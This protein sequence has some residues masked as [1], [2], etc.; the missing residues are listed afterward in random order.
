[1]R[2][3]RPFP[4]DRSN[5]PDEPI[6][7]VGLSCR[8]PG[9]PSPEAFWTLLREG[10]DAISPPPPERHLDART[11]GFLEHVDRFDP[12]FFDI[13]PREAA[14]MDPQQ[15]LI[16]ELSWEA[17]EDAGIVAADV[18]GRKVGVFVGSMWD[19][20][21]TALHRRGE[22]ATTRHS[23][24][25]LHRSIIANRVSYTWDLRGPSMAIDTG[26]SSS[27]VAVHTACE[28]LWRG[29]S[30]LALAAGV[31]LN[32]A[33]EST[34]RSEKFGG[35]SPDGR[36]FTFD[37]RANGYVRGEGAGLVVLKPLSRALADNDRVHCVIRGTAMNNDGASEGLTVPSARA[38]EDVLRE[39]Y[40][41]AGVDLTDVQYV[42]LHGTGT[43]KGDPLESSALGVV[44]GARRTP[45]TSLLVGSVKT[46]IGHLEAAAG[47]AGLIKTV[48][49]IKHRE[50]PPTL[51][52]RTPNPQISFDEWNL[53][54]QTALG[55]WP[56]GDAPLLAGVSSFGMGGTNCH[57]VLSDVPTVTG[58][59]RPG[60]DEAPDGP[61]G[62]ARAVRE[63]RPTGTSPLLPWV[64]TG[65]S[66]AAVRAQAELLR[67]HVADNPGPDPAGIGFSL[68]AHRTAFEERAVVLGHDTGDHLNGLEALVHGTPAPNL[69][70]GSARGAGRTAFLFTG[71]GG[72]RAG[73]GRRL[74]ATVPAFADALDE[75]CAQLDTRLPHRLKDLIF[76]ESGTP[77]AALLDQTRF[78]QAALFAVE[79][80]LFRLMRRCGVSPDFL[81]G[82]SIGELTAAHV[83]GVLSLADAC[84]LVAARGRLM[85]QATEGGAM[86]AIQAGEQEVRGALPDD[87]RLVSV[88]AL[89]GPQTT[90]ISGDREAVAAV[91]ARFRADG[92]KTKRLQ[93]SH[94]FHSP[95]MDGVLDEFRA[96]A[97]GLTYHAP[98]IPVV[99]NVTGRIAT[100]A[101]LCSPDYW[102]RHIRATVRYADGVRLLRSEGVTS[103]LELGP[104]GL[105]AMTRESLAA[106]DGRP[107]A[108]VVPLLRNSRPED[109]TVTTALAEA[110]VRGAPVDWTPLT[111]WAE[112]RVD[113][114][115]YAFQR[116]SYW[117]D[118]PGGPEAA[119]PDEAT[120]GAL[121]A[122]VP[123]PGEHADA[124]AADVPELVRA[125]A[126]TVLGHLSSDTVDTGRTFKE[127]GF[128]SLTAVEF[129]DRMAEATGLTDL[130]PT[131]IYNYPTPGELVRF[132]QAEL[133]G[134]QPAADAPQPVAAVGHEPIAIVGMGCRFPG[135]VR[136]PEDLWQFVAAGKDAVSGFPADRG[137]H[138]GEL[139]DPEN[140][141]VRYSREG[142]FLYDAAAFDAGFFG[143]SPREALAMDPQQ[144][145]VLETSWEALERAGIDPTALRGS[146]VGVFAGATAQ[147][148]GP[149]LGEPTQGGQ[150]Y[151]LTGN[152][153]SVIS[154]RVAYTLGLEGPAVTVDTAC[155]SSLAALHMA[156]RSLQ[157]GECTMALAGGV[158]V[159]AT[160]GMFVEFA[161]Q[162]GLAPDGRC[163]PFAASADG[164]G[165]SEGV[166]MVV[167]E[168][169]SDARR[170]GHQVLALI[171]G[172]AVNQDG[173]SNGLTAPNGPSQERVIRQA[174]ANARLAAQDID[175]VEAHGTG[176]KLGDPIEAQAL[177]ATYGRS[178]S[179]AE[180]LRLGSVKSNIGHTQA[181]AG[182][183]AVIKMVMALRHE[184]LPVSLHIDTPTP[185]VD[186][187]AGSVALLTESVPWPRGERT[188]RA[189]VSSFGIS[190]TNV[191]TILEE[192][193]A[194]PADV[195]EPSGPAG[196]VGP[197]GVV[198]WPLSAKTPQAL[199]GQAA[200][201]RAHLNGHADFDAADVGFSLAATRAA[202]EHR[203]VL[204]G[205]DRE[206][207]TAALDT[208]ARNA[209][210][211]TVIQGHAT[212]GAER[213][214]VFPGQG[215]QW[216]GMAVELLDSSTVFRERMHECAAALGTV[217]D[218]SLLDV[219]RGAPGAPT[220]ERVDVVQPALFA[221][222]VS[223]ARLWESCG[224]RPTAVVGHSQGE[225]AAACV[226]GGLSLPDAAKI[227]ALRSQALTTIS[228]LGGMVSLSLSAEHVRRLPCW[229][230]RLDLAVVNGPSSVVVSG[231]PAALEELLAVC[232]ARDIRAKQI[233]VSYAA[234][235]AQ[236]EAI[237]ER[238]LEALREIEPRSGEVPF[239]STVTGELL[240]TRELDADYWYR[241]LREPVQFER[242]MSTVLKKGHTLLFEVSPHPVLGIGAQ[243]AIDTLGGTGAVVG[244]LR[245]DDGGPRRFV[246]SLAQ[247]YVLGA[248]VHWPTVFAGSG[249][250]R[251][252]LPT[253]A[254]QHQR[255]W[256]TAP[257]TGRTG[258]GPE[259]A[260][261]QQ[262]WDIVERGDAEALATEAGI[263]ELDALRALLPALATWRR[264]QNEQELVDSWRYRIAWRPVAQ[265]PVGALPG[266]W[267]VLVHE[268]TA[269]RE[270]LLPDIL[271]A[272]TRS[273][274][275]VVPLTVPVGIGR[276]ELAERLRSASGEG[277]RPAGV[278][279]LLAPG[280][281]AGQEPPSESG[282]RDGTLTLVQALGDAGTDA[283]LWCVTQ[284]A[285]A[286]GAGDPVTAPAQAQ[287]WGL[288]RVAAVEFPQRWGGLV[289]LPTEPD[290]GVIGRLPAVLAGTDGENQ[291]ALR[292]AGV[293]VRRLV[294][295][296]RRENPGGRQW[297][298]QGTALVTGGTGALGAHAARWL[299]GQGA[300][301][302]VLVSRSGPRAEGVGSLE[303]ELTALGARVTTLACDVSDRDA[304]A[305]LLTGLDA[306]G[307]PVRTVV[308]T[309]GVIENV[310]LDSLT[311]ERFA[312]V[313]RAKAD[314]AQHLHEL[315]RDRDLDAFV[316]FSSVSGM[317]GSAGNGG[318]AAANAFQDALA[319]YRRSQ[320]L[321]ATSVIWGPWS[322]GGMT[323]RDGMDTAVVRHGIRLLEPAPAIGTLRQYLDDDAPA[324]V[325][326]DVDWAAF[327]P[328]FTAKCP[329]RLFDE[330][331]EVQRVL[332][333]SAAPV[334]AG[335]TTADADAATWA[336]RL[337]ERSAAQRREAASEL[338]RAQAATVLGYADADAIGDRSTFKELGVDSVMAVELRNRLQDGTG[339]RLPVTVVFDH[340]SP[341][342]LVDLLLETAFGDGEEN[343][344]ALPEPDAGRA[345]ELLDAEQRINEMDADD[346]VR[347]MLGEE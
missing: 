111:G 270:P 90:V 37:A 42:E 185:H 145:L 105:T 134:G 347:L 41:K 128:D 53:R 132:L 191:H 323:A 103:Y 80:A 345:R 73:M 263:Q 6:A 61:A 7:V 251:T 226:A 79:V 205:D 63:H 129:R 154:G 112:A 64:I 167:L 126:A 59:A 221:V 201:L 284:G 24:T 9:A 172:S 319:E 210:S 76:A 131:L 314:A 56:R 72:Q 57:V 312:A 97:G 109:H 179:G 324:P 147:D 39:A 89:N 140:P 55:P 249:A 19:D 329:S 260:A 207:L 298:P 136:S 216:A 69:V 286:V 296:P 157:Q 209:P 202:F 36:C 315:T 115:T 144:R 212:T 316:L 328:A 281:P 238:L 66:D 125:S 346:L 292:S 104:G 331:P 206:A 302:I 108:A 67:E 186:W 275:E 174:L 235:S 340:P 95:H 190:G 22:D 272:L 133:A 208:L 261:E 58:S 268:D 247:A 344:E 332:R 335:A 45:D 237:R 130:A 241:N 308:H 161:Q 285:V 197:A 195:Q 8:F 10:V 173:A 168:R 218:W 148:Y 77:E 305:G 239:Y 100:T 343:H 242:A 116:R 2:T 262:F 336:Q 153:A 5:V 294:R 322:G 271:G 122:P 229:D 313:V 182:I 245:R 155:S 96:V 29:E 303:E 99:S 177:V 164:T 217:V 35:L 194:V 117:F 142:G 259:G 310:P 123:V 143:I 102:T 86:A 113:L 12:E 279:S 236:V 295:A 110:F 230:E 106:S 31:N 282:H 159:M 25:G 244:S 304:V 258:T 175:A 253:Y 11:G 250:A 92:R 151:T 341:G 170:H 269:H 320:G 152:T 267:L 301:H 243:E 138:Q 223:L 18:K 198:A 330:V 81:L 26:Q 307:D 118:G 280:T 119:E 181:A 84:T 180:P 28:S 233:P 289:D 318:Y 38:Q 200:A 51:N 141:D 248:P 293:F 287:V 160:P 183:A 228:G 82:H 70:R 291:V 184:Q 334:P 274:A 15:R 321:P 213:V 158:T 27:L 333:E 137:W 288:G 13:S 192:A 227:V 146:Q 225:I 257:G 139:R 20:Y 325:V 107:G 68:A 254:F 264:R 98:E 87:G 317:W 16:L 256:L 171:R 44:F 149:R 75:V 176:T 32:I 342:K 150:G 224:V 71:Q 52:F 204:I 252:D 163:K 265:A 306:A 74:H 277:A 309:A 60:P 297:T 156:S 220:L 273:G 124:A 231:E 211:E 290:G 203:A 299:A 339:L 120:A 219:L 48:L 278:L 54:V 4:A 34:R 23:M 311:P 214:F 326:A 196:A 91:A 62:L 166:G 266:R 189:G 121:P 49:S 300:E 178:R 50:L 232:A 33:P 169:L 78:T 276:G 94:A 17:F 222:M 88:A 327:F 187:S 85:Q 199:R 283:R 165:W 47:I 101:E 162:R 83:A 1:M 14:A 246:T 43:K 30:A 255:Y 65:R 234:H 135:G 114:P 337:A 127:L 215:A 338:V 46:N 240:D 40:E 21:A 193:P 3:A 188:R 93:V